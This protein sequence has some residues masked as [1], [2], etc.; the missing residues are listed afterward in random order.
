M[1]TISHIATTSNTSN[2]SSYVSGSFTPVNGDLLV[3]KVLVTDTLNNA[4]TLTAS[5]NGITFSLVQSTV[6][7][8]STGHVYIFIAD[9]KVGASPSSMTVTINVTGDAGTGTVIT[10]LAAVGMTNVGTAAVAQVAEQENRAA[11]NTPTVTFA[12]NITAGN[13]VIIG[14]SANENPIAA[15]SPSGFTEDID[16]GYANPTSGWQVCHIDSHAGGTGIVAYSATVATRGSTFAI[17]LVPGG[18]GTTAIGKNIQLVWDTDV[19]IGK[20][21]QLVWDVKSIIAKT[22]QN[23]WNTAQAVGKNLGLVWLTNAVISKT[24]QLVWNTRRTATQ[25]LDIL[26]DVK[27]PIGKNNQLIWNTLT[28]GIQAGKDFALVWNIRKIVFDVGASLLGPSWNADFSSG[29]DNWDNPTNENTTITNDGG[30]LKVERTGTTGFFGTQTD[31]HTNDPAYNEGIL[32]FSFRIRSN[33]E[34]I[35]M[36]LFADDNNNR[37]DMFQT[38]R[39]FIE[40][41]TVSLIGSW[42]RSAQDL[43]H[44]EIG[45]NTSYPAGT[46]VWIDNFEVRALDDTSLTLRYNVRKAIAN[47]LQTVWDT[48]SKVSKDVQLVWNVFTFIGKVLGLIWNVKT[49]A[50]KS[51]QIIWNVKTLIAKS[52]QV[53]WDVL[54]NQLVAAKSLGLVWNVKQAI[55]KPLQLVWTVRTT[56]Q[57]FITL[58]YNVLTFIGKNIQLRWNQ[59]QVV[60]DDLTLQWNA[61]YTRAWTTVPTTPTSTYSEI[62]LSTT[63]TLIPADSDIWTEVIV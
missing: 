22:L 55:N 3:C 41:R 59:R 10:V 2:L 1:A 34:N 57:K 45:S 60:G 20:D 24:L 30:E 26:W 23:I 16:T 32:Q 49:L 27:A 14:A 4:P 28:N 62:D 33:V 29:I 19:P 54:S 39:A 38:F 46:A 40:P 11:S 44:V 36:F 53:V 48:K 31:L 13:P 15:T 5:A 37:A 63:W 18:G 35:D 6:T 17:E 42:P 7:D 25:W 21:L 52:L 51:L 56:L 9:Q 12:S 58:R 50:T 61:Y 47:S 8:A 43:K